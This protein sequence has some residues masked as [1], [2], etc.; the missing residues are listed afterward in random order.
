MEVTLIFFFTNTQNAF[1]SLRLLVTTK[2][3]VESGS[4]V[5]GSITQESQAS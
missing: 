3:K 5:Y 2:G 4:M 1:F